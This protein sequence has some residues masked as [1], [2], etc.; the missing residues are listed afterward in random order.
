ML[1]GMLSQNVNENLKNQRSKWKRS[2]GCYL[3]MWMRISKVNCFKGQKKS[4]Q[5]GVTS[6]HFNFRVNPVVMMLRLD[7][8]APSSEQSG[9][10]WHSPP[11]QIEFV[12][13]G[14][15]LTFLRL[16]LVFIFSE[17]ANFILLTFLSNP[18]FCPLFSIFSL[19]FIIFQFFHAFL[20][21]CS[22]GLACRAGRRAASTSTQPTLSQIHLTHKKSQTFRRQKRF[23][24]INQISLNCS[25]VIK[26][27]SV[28]CNYKEN[29]K[30][31]LWSMIPTPR[32]LCICNCICSRIC[33][34]N[35]RCIC[36]RIWWR[37]VGYRQSS[38]DW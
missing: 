15:D 34:C 17:Y 24:N 2:K 25:K 21:F 6:P 35:W 9:Q 19:L 36:V 7:E 5:R 16:L 22:S 14:R 23:V 31:I 27:C 20:F 10:N 32:N 38:A 30:P 37:L 12:V 29:H 1:E 8:E 13:R 33:N 28:C 18:K 4:V 3:K 11:S 26:I